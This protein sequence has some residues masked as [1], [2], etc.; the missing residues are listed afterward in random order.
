MIMIRFLKEIYLTW[1]TVGFRLRSGRGWGPIMDAGKGVFIIAII[2]FFILAGIE[3]Y[4]EIFVGTKILFSSRWAFIAAGLA[5]YYANY[6]V[7]ITRGHGL[8]FERE[9]DNLKK[10]RKVLLQVS[11]AV[12]LI[13][14]IVFIN[15]SLSA[16]HRFFHIIPKSGF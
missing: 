12:L 9:F 8:R 14:T 10:S 15:F 13:M 11:C 3:G 7:L 16:Y 6:Y 4:I 1:F 2:M 5:V